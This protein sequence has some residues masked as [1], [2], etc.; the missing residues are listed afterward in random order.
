MARRGR[1]ALCD[2]LEVDESVASSEPRLCKCRPVA[3]TIRCR[4][5]LSHLR[6][7]WR[8]WGRT[9]TACGVAT[10]PDL[11]GQNAQVLTAQRSVGARIAK[12]FSQSR[13]AS[14]RDQISLPDSDFVPKSL[15]LN[16]ARPRLNWAA[17]LTR[18]S[19]TGFRSPRATSY[20]ESLP[21]I[22]RM[23]NLRV[24]SQRLI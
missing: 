17:P 15:P 21:A 4:C 16:Q 22:C 24:Q 5:A 12:V 9:L 7:G 18:T 2:I 14:G 23:V 13:C 19:G 10:V 11:A 8:G 6:E 3:R 20:T 1:W